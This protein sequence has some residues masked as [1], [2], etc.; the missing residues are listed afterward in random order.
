MNL[1]RKIL[2]LIVLFVAIS[3]AAVFFGILPLISAVQTK[4]VEVQEKRIKL[5]T[6]K[7]E[8]EN[9]VVLS[10]NFN[11]VSSQIQNL[12]SLV[13]KSNNSLTFI[14]ALEKYADESGLSFDLD[15]AELQASHDIQAVP[16]AIRVQGPFHGILSFLQTLDTSPYYIVVSSVRMLQ[17]DESRIEMTLQG[18][19]FWVEDE[20]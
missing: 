3:G 15:L 1:Q 18:N 10:R 9:F 2:I 5:A 11:S 19:T 7:K 12:D 4:T 14:S 8:Q 16:T 17:L 6:V 20:L 13:L